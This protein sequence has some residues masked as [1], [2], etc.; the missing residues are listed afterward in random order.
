MRYRGVGCM[1]S[2][3]FVAAREGATSSGRFI[4]PF[5]EITARASA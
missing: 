1:P 2:S 4:R 3:P 5:K